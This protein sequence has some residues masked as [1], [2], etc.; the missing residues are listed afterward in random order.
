MQACVACKHTQHAHLPMYAFVRGRRAAGSEAVDRS[1]S[2]LAVRHVRAAFRGGGWQV[3]AFNRSSARSSMRVSG[4]E[5]LPD[6]APRR[7][8]AALLRRRNVDGTNSL[9]QVGGAS[10]SRALACAPRRAARNRSYRR[11]AGRTG[12]RAEGPPEPAGLG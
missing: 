1:R 4:A 6:A 12:S 11:R 5:A 3:Y 8:S 10:S 2:G 9:A 7:S